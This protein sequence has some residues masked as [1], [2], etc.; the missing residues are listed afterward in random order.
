MGSTIHLTYCI[1]YGRFDI[2]RHSQFPAP[3]MQLCFRREQTHRL[4]LVAYIRLP[5]GLSL[6]YRNSHLTMPFK[7]FTAFILGSPL[8]SGHVRAAW[9]PST[10]HTF[11]SGLFWP[12]SD[13]PS[14]GQANDTGRGRGGG[15]S[16]VSL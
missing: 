3:F 8:P 4:K 6:G 13:V 9:G 14:T 12:L 1:N 5:W 11:T 2:A 16:Y 10:S 15:R 7:G